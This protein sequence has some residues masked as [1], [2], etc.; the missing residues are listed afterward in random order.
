[1][2]Q[3]RVY[4]KKIPAQLHRKLNTKITGGME[5]RKE[6]VRNPG[7]RQVHCRSSRV[8]EVNA[9]SMHVNHRE[10]RDKSD[11]SVS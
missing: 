7:P 9:D 5:S 1:M 6:I 3:W 11:P 2:G 4:T 8:L 10:P